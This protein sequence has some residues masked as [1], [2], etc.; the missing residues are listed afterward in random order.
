MNLL[1]IDMYE[2]MSNE[3]SK[4]INKNMKTYILANIKSE[5]T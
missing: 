3:L 1:I 5:K 4:T 2:K